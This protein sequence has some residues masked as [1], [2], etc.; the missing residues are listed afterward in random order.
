[1]HGMVIV[2]MC[3]IFIAVQRNLLK[4]GLKMMSSSDELAVRSY[5]QSTALEKVS[6]LFLYICCT[7]DMQWS[8]FEFLQYTRINS[9]LQCL[10]LSICLYSI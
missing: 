10:C 9:Q 3:L 8:D 5:I 1:M 2:Y 7:V 6:G 4:N